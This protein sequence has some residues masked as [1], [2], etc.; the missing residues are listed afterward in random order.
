MVVLNL[1]PPLLGSMMQTTISLWQ[2]VSPPITASS[3]SSSLAQST[4]NNFVRLTSSGK[5]PA[6]L[7]AGAHQSGHAIEP[8]AKIRDAV[9]S[10][11]SVPAKRS[12]VNLSTATTRKCISTPADTDID[13][14]SDGDAL[15]EDTVDNDDEMPDLQDCSDDDDD[16]DACLAEEEF[17]RNQACYK[18]LP[19][20]SVDEWEKL[21]T[22]KCESIATCDL[23]QC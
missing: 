12:A 14:S 20:E 10:V 19:V 13:T 16:K 1:H 17:D 18:T 15:F 7:V 2:L 22:L 4:I 23:I 3:L 5:V 9:P 11:S 21:F 8:S 6:S